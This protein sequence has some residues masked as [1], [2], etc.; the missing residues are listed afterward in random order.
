MQKLISVKIK[1]NDIVCNFAS[2]LAEQNVPVVISKDDD[3]ALEIEMELEKLNLILLNL[4]PSCMT[5]PPWQLS[6]FLKISSCSGDI[7]KRIPRH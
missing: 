3:I 7:Y 4:K 1:K 2:E 5:T 6:Y